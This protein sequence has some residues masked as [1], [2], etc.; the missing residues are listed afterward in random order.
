MLFISVWRL[1]LAFS[2][3]SG[4]ESVK[5]YVRKNSYDNVTNPTIYNVHS[6]G[7][8]YTCQIPSNVHFTSSEIESLKSSSEMK[9]EKDNA[10]EVIKEF[11]LQHRNNTAFKEIGYWK[12]L[13]RFDHDIQQFH[14]DIYDGIMRVDNYKL[15]AWSDNDDNDSFDSIP[16]YKDDNSKNPYLS[17]SDFELITSDDG[18]KYVSQ[19]IG[20]GEICDITGRRRVTTI[21]YYC[22]EQDI[23]PHIRNI[24]EWRTCEYIFDIESIYF[25]S[26]DMWTEPKT[27]SNNVISCDLK[28]EDEID[29]EIRTNPSISIGS[30][31]NKLEPLSPGIF[32]L[33]NT[34]NSKFD[35]LLT[36]NYNLWENETQNEGFQKLLTDISLGF[37]RYIKNLRL[38]ITESEVKVVKLTDPIKII[39][40]V[41]D[42]DRSLIGDVVLEQ[43]EN[44]FIVSYFTDEESPIDTNCLSC[45]L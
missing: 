43:D 30:A 6:S 11:N 33:K 21:N 12:Y 37:Q 39:F 24:H 1:L 45:I 7:E 15:A 25:C 16:Y 34:T 23:N 8:E 38:T 18:T 32:L 13:V 3:V 29:E 19:R 27:S 26:F 42:I 35:L 2:V 10:I 28:V 20:N 40:D 17:T 41:Y 36:R 9:L 4:D 5:Y 14:T 44:G 31:K 22:S